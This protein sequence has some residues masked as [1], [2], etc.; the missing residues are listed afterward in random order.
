MGRS[1]ISFGEL[2]EG[3]NAG[4]LQIFGRKKMASDQ[5][6]PLIQSV[7]SCDIIPLYIY[8]Y[9]YNHSIILAIYSTFYSGA[10]QLDSVYILFAAGYRSHVFRTFSRARLQE[11]DPMESYG[12]SASLAATKVQA[13]WAP[14]GTWWCEFCMRETIQW[15]GISGHWIVWGGLGNRWEHSGV[16]VVVVV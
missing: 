2:V 11:L 4:N 3:T 16:V 9:I 6:F 8:I 15:P 1:I 13:I 14:E 12:E 7:E 10:V 5:D